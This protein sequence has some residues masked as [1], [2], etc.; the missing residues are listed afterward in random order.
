M[1]NILFPKA[2]ECSSLVPS[3][4]TYKLFSLPLLFQVGHDTHLGIDTQVSLQ[5]ISRLVYED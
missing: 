1:S 5:S 4:S 3:T 2:S